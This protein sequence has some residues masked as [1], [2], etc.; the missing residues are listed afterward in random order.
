MR[1]YFS[2]PKLSYTNTNCAFI[3][4]KSHFSHNYQSVNKTW[5]KY[6]SS[7]ANGEDMHVCKAKV[8][9]SML[10]S[11]SNTNPHAQ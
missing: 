10:M 11:R 9:M 1:T 8:Q 7:Q 6:E 4:Y 3:N 5:D 2:L